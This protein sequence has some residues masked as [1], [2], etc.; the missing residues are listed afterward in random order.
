MFYSKPYN[1]I[2]DN[3]LFIVSIEHDMLKYENIIG[4]NI[5][6][7]TYQ[8]LINLGHVESNVI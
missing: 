2:L 7:Y 8:D 5:T 4:E 1:S 3:S 6:E